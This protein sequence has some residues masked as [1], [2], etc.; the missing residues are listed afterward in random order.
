MTSPWLRLIRIH[1]AS[2]TQPVVLLG[3]VLADVRIGW[4][5]IP[6]ALFAVV[7]HAGGFLQNNILDFRHDRLDPAKAHFPLISGEVSLR[8]AKGLFTGLTVLTFLAG[9]C[10]SH[11]RW[12]SIIFLV[13]LMGFGWLY[14]WRCKQDVLSPAYIA[15]AFVSLPLFSYFAYAFRLTPLIIWSLFYMAFLMLFQIAVEGYMKDIQSDKVSLLKRLGTVYHENG[16]IDVSF[17]T[18]LF[19]WGLKVPGLILFVVIWH[20]AGSDTFSFWLGLT[21]ASGVLGAS[22]M[23]MKSG[24]FDNRKRVRLCAII[25]VLSYNLLVIALQG[26][27]GWSTT[28]FLIV[29]PIGWFLLF[30]RLTWNTWITPR[31]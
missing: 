24:T 21:I 30:N 7:Y 17:R 6:Y 5:W 3:L 31:V 27:M 25:E 16:R 12:L 9:L 29:C 26:Q 11:G 2:L 23:L 19:A 14:N 28:I 1:T 8:H 4:R 13:S 10:L 22:Y 15:T 20:L 18:K